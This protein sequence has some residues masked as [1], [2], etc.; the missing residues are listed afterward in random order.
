MTSTISHIAVLTGDLVGSTSLSPAQLAQ[1]FDALADCAAMQADWHGAPLHFTRQRGDGWQVALARPALALRSA[2]AFRAALRCEGGEF[3]SYIS[4]AEGE[5]A[6]KLGPD[7]NA[8]TAKV[9]VTSGD[10]LDM[11]KLLSLSERMVY[12]DDAYGQGGPL[13]AVAV[14][15]D[16]I[17]QGWTPAQAAAILP[18]LAR[19]DEPSYT[20]VAKA[21]GKSRQAVTKA[22]DAAGY[23]ALKRALHSIEEAAD[24]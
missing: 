22:L 4:I 15:A 18:F 8:E 7:L 19:G 21:L 24:D 10:G 9:F 12:V 1:A 17:S 14:L 11:L 23:P 13:N 3:D 16:H 20:E 5:V 6:G 2:L